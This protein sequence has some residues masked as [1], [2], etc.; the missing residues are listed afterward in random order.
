MD[1]TISISVRIPT[2]VCNE[3]DKIAK[4]DQLDRSDIIRDALRTYVDSVNSHRCPECDTVNE[5]DAKYCKNCGKAIAVSKD[6][7]LN[8]LIEN[9]DVDPDVLIQALKQYQKNKN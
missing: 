1:D 3:L 5:P 2:W 7:E 9:L 8:K 4:E 6:E